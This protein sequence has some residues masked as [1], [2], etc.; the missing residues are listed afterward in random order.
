M[1]YLNKEK[2]E[3]VMHLYDDSIFPDGL[4]NV[5]PRYAITRGN[6]LMVNMSD[7]LIVYARDTTGNAGRL[8]EYAI[9]REKRG[10]LK[11]TEIE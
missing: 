11:V 6:R 2:Y 1:H 7:Y 3:D 9:R 4:E 10:L 8:L 5:H